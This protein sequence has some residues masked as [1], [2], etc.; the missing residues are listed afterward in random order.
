MSRS[1]GTDADV[2]GVAKRM[3]D[4]LRGFALALVSDDAPVSAALLTQLAED[5]ATRGDVG[6]LLLGHPDSQRA[7]FGLRALAGLHQLVLAG[8]APQLSAEIASA[9]RS[10]P[11][12]A[13]ID[14][15]RLWLTARDV[16]LR[17]P[18]AMS[19]ALGR[20]VQQ[21]HPARAGALLRGLSMLPLARVRLLE[22]GACAGLNLLLD[23]YHW[24]GTGWEWGPS[25]SPLSLTADGPHPGE[26]EIVERAGCD[27]APRDPG[28]PADALILRSFLPVEHTEDLRRLEAAIAVA[29]LIR[30]RVDQAD[31]AP[32]LAKYLAEPAEG[33]VLTVV[34]HSL[35][36]HYLTPDHRSAVEAVLRDAARSGPVVRIAY[37]PSTWGAPVRLQVITYP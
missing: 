32:W 16:F 33:G 27:L 21:H 30:P 31:A 2:G 24:R 20:P 19:A 15:I 14:A 3:C 34:W 11:M 10:G 8:Q 35:V 23:H 1:P 12:R 25:A 18:D 29:A 36:W 28:D 5:I 9:L 26:L 6:R 7:L 17:H 37:E 13:E 22:I 4:E